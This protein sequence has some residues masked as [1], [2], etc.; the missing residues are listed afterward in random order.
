M[1]L[2]KLFSLTAMSRNIHVDKMDQ[3]LGLKNDKSE[4]YALTNAIL[5]TDDLII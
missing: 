1:S 3:T 5:R 4:R 2:D